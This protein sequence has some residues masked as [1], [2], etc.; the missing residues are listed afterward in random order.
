MPQPGTGGRQIEIVAEMKPVTVPTGLDGEALSV[1]RPGVT[2]KGC[3]RPK[4]SAKST[5]RRSKPFVGFFASA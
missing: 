4:L 5:A 2:L 3:S 1:D